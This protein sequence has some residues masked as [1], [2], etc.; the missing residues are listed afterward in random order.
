MLEFVGDGFFED[1]QELV[2]GALEGLFGALGGRG[3]EEGSGED[4]EAG[5][6]ACGAVLEDAGVGEQVV[7]VVEGGGH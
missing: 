1:G 3:A 4:A 6:L 5:G 2:E 7:D